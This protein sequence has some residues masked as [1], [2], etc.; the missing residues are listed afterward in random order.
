MQRMGKRIV[1][2]RRE[3]GW[4]QETLAE[5]LNVTA[6]AVSK[7][8]TGASCPDISLLPLLAR[9]LDTSIDCLMTGE[10]EAAQGIAGSLKIVVTHESGEHAD[11]ALPLAMLYQSRAEHHPNIISADFG[12]KGGQVEVDLDGVLTLVE[13]GM[14]G[15]LMSIRAGKNTVEV[16]AER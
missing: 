11:V 5:R 2:K 16:F 14:T 10:G 8:E 4:T 13:R 9:A 6:Q 12:E 7:W 15:K 3:R 1:E